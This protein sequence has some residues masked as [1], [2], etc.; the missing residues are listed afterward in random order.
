MSF[1]RLQQLLVVILWLI[2]SCAFPASGPLQSSRGLEAYTVPMVV[3]FI[4][5]LKSLHLCYKA[6]GLWQAIIYVVKSDTK[7][8]SHTS[9]TKL[10]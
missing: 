4:L 3:S 7:L 6:F 5:L 8:S 9:E 10:E 2:F 1:T